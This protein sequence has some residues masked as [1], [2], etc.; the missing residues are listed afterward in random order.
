MGQRRDVAML[1]TLDLKFFSINM[2][3]SNL[4]VSTLDILP[5]FFNSANSLNLMRFTVTGVDL[6]LNTRTLI[7]YF[8]MI[9]LRI[10][11]HMKQ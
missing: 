9:A 1:K 7:P 8:Y 5:S 2:R 6:V 11:L 4:S 10:S 3:L